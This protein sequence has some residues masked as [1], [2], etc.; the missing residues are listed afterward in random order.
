MTQ[1]HTQHNMTT[2]GSPP[3]SVA[4]INAKRYV[5]S[6]M[7]SG[8][9]D[10]KVEE[11]VQYLLYCCLSQKS[12]LVKRSDINKNILKEHSRAFLIVFEQVRDRLKNIFGFEL[13]E[14]DD[15]QEKFGIKNQFQFD[16]SVHN[17]A[18][19]NAN[20]T[21]NEINK[22]EELELCAKYSFLIITLTIIFMNDNEIEAT[23]LWECLKCIDLARAEKRNPFIGDVEKYFTSELVKDGYLEYEKD[24]RTDPPIF[25]FKW[26]YRARLE[27][28]KVSL[29]DFVCEVYG[30]LDVI[31]PSDWQT[32]YM[33]AQKTD[34]QHHSEI[35]DLESTQVQQT[36]TRVRV[37]RDH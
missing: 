17:K 21:L 29:L 6:N 8:L 1:S 27:V 13:S 35:N 28:S 5:D 34:E 25:K 15:K 18:L 33:D 37:K 31:K 11:T 7:D 22:N 24:S 10:R 32:Q 23:Q 20:G 9:F 36:Q 14:L 26:G 12:V 16:M 2:N 3:S 19:A 30:G 4:M